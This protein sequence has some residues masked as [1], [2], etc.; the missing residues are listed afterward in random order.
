MTNP[1]VIISARFMPD[2]HR[3]KFLGDPAQKLAFWLSVVSI[4]F[5]GALLLWLKTDV[6]NVKNEL[7]QED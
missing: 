1:M 4:V 6:L 2:I 7:E 3:P 5:L